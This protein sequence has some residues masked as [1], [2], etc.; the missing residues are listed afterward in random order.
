MKK[1]PLF[2][3]KLVL[4]F[5]TIDKDEKIVN[6]NCLNAVLLSHIKKICG[7]E[8]IS[9]SIDLALENG[10]VMDLSSKPKDYAKHYLDNRGPYVLVKIIENGTDTLIKDYLDE[11]IHYIPLLDSFPVDKVKFSGNICFIFSPSCQKK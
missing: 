2:V 10:Q 6:S 9:E 5:L 8:E 3:L 11:S 7:F 4:P 1:C